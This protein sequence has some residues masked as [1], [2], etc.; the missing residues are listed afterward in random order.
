MRNHYNAQQRRNIAPHTRQLVVSYNQNSAPGGAQ[1]FNVDLWAPT[2]LIGRA[3]LTDGSDEKVSVTQMSDTLMMHNQCTF[4]IHMRIIKVKCRRQYDSTTA[5]GPIA[6][7]AI[8]AFN[9]ASVPFADPTTSTTFRRYYKIL[10]NRVRMLPAGRM[11]T[12]RRSI[13]RKAGMIMTGQVEG[14]SNY[15]AYRGMYTYII[16]F[17]SIPVAETGTTEPDQL[18]V[19]TSATALSCTHIR[20]IVYRLME[21]NDPDTAVYGTPDNP[22]TQSVVYN[23][24]VPM[25][26]GS[27]Y[28]QIAGTVEQPPILVNDPIG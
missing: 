25:T 14:R 4:P 23:Q 24:G 22:V 10:S 12:L 3:V 17:S 11:T 5:N 1:L 13:Y 6:M 16:M 8:N 20:K 28:G 19:G 9:P 18:Q 21:D 7:L 26:Y 15:W 27:V 2:D